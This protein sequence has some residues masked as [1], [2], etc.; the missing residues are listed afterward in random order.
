[1]N[2]GDSAA[3]NQGLGVDRECR[4]NPIQRGFDSPVATVGRDR[5]F[6]ERTPVGAHH[7][8]QLGELLNSGLEGLQVAR[9]LGAHSLQAQVDSVRS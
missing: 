5:S 2:D 4:D 7:G 8:R 3:W 1:L 6:R 9:D